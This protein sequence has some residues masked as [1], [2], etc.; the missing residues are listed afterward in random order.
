MTATDWVGLTIN[1]VI[2]IAL[3]VLFYWVFNPKNKEKLEA[4]RHLPFRDESDTS[5]NKHG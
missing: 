2:F 3:L 4:H 5:G 1:V